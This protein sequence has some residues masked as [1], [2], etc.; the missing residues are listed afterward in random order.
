MIIDKKFQYY[1]FEKVETFAQKLGHNSFEYFN[2]NQQNVGCWFERTI[3]LEYKRN[4][5]NEGRCTYQFG[6]DFSAYEHE[7]KTEDTKIKFGVG[8]YLT[9]P[10]IDAFWIKYQGYSHYGGIK[11][12]NEI[13]TMS[14]ARPRLFE[15]FENLYGVKFEICTYKEL[16]FAHI[17]KLF[18]QIE[19]NYYE[20][21]EPEFKQKADIYYLDKELNNPIDN[22][23]DN[24]DIDI[25]SDRLMLKLILAKLTNNPN[26]NKIYEFLKN[27]GTEAAEKYKDER[28]EEIKRAAINFNV[29]VDKIHRDLQN[30]N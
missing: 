17:D 18:E 22:Y 4:N 25:K 3:N 26:Y 13:K 15:Y 12:L 21:V 14:I 5:W 28:D 24:N 8:Y 6:I 10:Y 9:L 11:G 29:R 27:L 19:Q 30:I 20:M 1:F 23:N 16:S 2:R 7:E